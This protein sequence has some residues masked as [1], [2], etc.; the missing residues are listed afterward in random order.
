M[1]SRVKQIL[2]H[3]KSEYQVSQPLTSTALKLDDS[4]EES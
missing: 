2:H 3:E 1:S 4:L